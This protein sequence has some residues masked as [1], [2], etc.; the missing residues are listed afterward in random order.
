MFCFS[1]FEKESGA[2]LASETIGVDTSIA[3]YTQLLSVLTWLFLITLI[4][5]YQ[6]LAKHC[7]TTL[8]VTIYLKSIKTTFCEVKLGKKDNI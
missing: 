3:R 7:F 1:A 2:Y 6:T 4:I 5:L 8:G